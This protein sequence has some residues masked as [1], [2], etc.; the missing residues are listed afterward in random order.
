MMERDI[1]RQDVFN[2]IQNGQIIEAYDESTPYEG[3]LIFGTAEKKPLHIVISW[4]EENCISYII[5]SYVPD[6][7]HFELDWKTRKIRRE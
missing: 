1:S 4:D 3:F 7:H 6:E 5:T 2:A